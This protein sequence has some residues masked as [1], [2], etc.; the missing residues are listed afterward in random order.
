MLLHYVLTFLRSTN[1]LSE[2]FRLLISSSYL[3]RNVQ[4]L[5]ECVCGMSLNTLVYKHARFK[6]LCRT[7]PVI[8]L[9]LEVFYQL[10]MSRRP[11]SRR[12]FSLPRPPSL[13]AQVS[14][15]GLK[16]NINHNLVWRLVCSCRRDHFVSS[17]LFCCSG[18]TPG[19]DKKRKGNIEKRKQRFLMVNEN[20]YML[21]G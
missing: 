1:S 5:L 21:C 9:A 6:T 10:V 12:T 17:I 4:S 14:N 16:H 11:Y 7:F 2:S 3:R 19:K 8:S 20:A 18:S 15:V 13:S